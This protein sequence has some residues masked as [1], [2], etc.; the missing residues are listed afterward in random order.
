MVQKMAWVFLAAA[1]A[2]TSPAPAQKENACEADEKTFCSKS[3]GLLILKCLVDHFDELSAGCKK[4][5]EPARMRFESAKT[6][7]A[8]GAADSKP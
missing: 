6:P 1:I 7:A 3:Q 4:Q 5:V 2:M 8:A